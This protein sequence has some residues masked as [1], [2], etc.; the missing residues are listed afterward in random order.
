MKEIIKAALFALF[1]G[2]FSV[3]GLLAQGTYTAA[4]CNQSD[5]NAVI[6]GPT[7]TAV[8]GD[9]INIPSGSCTWSTNVTIDGVAI[10][11]IGAGSANTVITD[12]LSDGASSLF[13]VGSVPVSSYLMRISSMSIQPASTVTNG[14]SPISIAG[15]CSSTTCPNVRVDNMNFSAWSETSNGTQSA[16]MIRTDNVFGVIDHNT[17]PVGGYLGNN[18]LSA[19]LGVGAYGDNSWAERDSFGTPNAVYY[20]NNTLIC[21]VNCAAQ[22]CDIAPQQGAIGGCRVVVRFNTFSS[23]GFGMTYTHGTDS[24]DRPR[25][26]RQFETYGNAAT[27]QNTSQGCQAGTVLRSGV[28]M[29]FG[30][31]FAL[32]SGSWW[33]NTVSLNTYRTWAGFP[34]GGY[35][36]GQGSYDSNDN[37]IYASGTFT[38]VSTSGGVLT[39]T[40]STKSWSANQWVSNG[41]PYSIVDT[42]TTTSGWNPGYE[43][44]ANASSTLS[45]AYYGDDYYNGP[46]A[47]NVGDSYKILRASVCMD[48]PSRSGGTLLS[49]STPSTGWV[50]E[51]L[52]PAYEWMDSGTVLHGT[53]GSDTAKLI[54]NRDWYS[55][56][57]SGEQ[58]SATS[59]FNGTSGVGWGST[60]N[61]PTTCT[62]GVAYWA[63]DQGSWNQSGNGFGNGVL[64]QCTAT[65]T[66]T[67][68]YTPYTYPHPLIGGTTVL[69]PPSNVQAVGH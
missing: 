18:N 33:N 59:P 34:P 13:N 41:S 43:I 26:G 53:F 23:T 40:D 19:Y 42:T 25:G 37:T 27:C 28:L 24:D 10:Q 39:V 64:F 15:V 5:V 3:T 63:T 31:T 65:N 20:E 9:T 17:G 29:Q 22:D 62:T 32:G 4:S 38:A 67:A 66:W 61:R 35:C 16:W 46:P 68:Y 54:A 57:Q 60:A 48:Q 36:A 6:N 56:N 45:A 12:A 52:D 30:N 58:T 49:G 55:D 14:F 11:I 50:N 2:L 7:H 69:A 21:G 8:S 1:F 44:T 51:V 47:F